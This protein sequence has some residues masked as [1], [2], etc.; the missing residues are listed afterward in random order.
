[1]EK[2]PH[3]LPEL[4]TI[5]FIGL[6][7]MGF[8]MAQHLA[9]AGFTVLPYDRD[10]S[11]IER[12][13]DAQGG[14]PS[15]SLADLGAQA[16]VIITMLPTS[17][18]V[19]DVIAGD[20]GVVDG[21]SAGK[22]VAD[23]STSNPHDTRQLGTFL[24]ERGVHMIDAPVAG[25][26][27]FA[28]DGSLDILTGGERRVADHLAPVFAAMGRKTHYCGALGSAHAMKALNNY[29]NAAIMS[30]YLEALVAGRAFGIDE[31]TLIE[32]IEAA[33]LERNHPYE[34][35]IKGH[36]LPRKFA[37][38][39]AMSLIAKDVQIAVDTMHNLGLPAPLAEA[40]SDVWHRASEQLGGDLDQTEIA[41]FWE[42]PA[43]VELGHRT[44]K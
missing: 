29:V 15:A 26:V 8:P 31:K 9:R 11:V 43:G 7:R 5:G 1:M 27:I 39:M 12:F 2:E 10:A 25:G 19:R 16:D 42:I 33:T 3:K 20:G 44:Q 35:K 34:K 41:K 32:S 37:S 38:G 36:V 18:I 17:T 22:I 30:V 24:E 13:S 23:M 28:E 4:K 40:L 6:G 14:E 21:V